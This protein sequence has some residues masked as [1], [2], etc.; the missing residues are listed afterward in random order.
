[1]LLTERL[2]IVLVDEQSKIACRLPTVVD[3]MNFVGWF[4]AAAL[5][6]AHR[7]VSQLVTA[8]AVRPAPCSE[9]IPTVPL[10][11]R[12][13]LSL[14]II[15]GDVLRAEFLPSEFETARLLTEV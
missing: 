7:R 13:V 12:G 9:R 3:V 6:F 5:V 4:Y 11:S 2:E 10:R 1:M 8:C 14:L 15:V